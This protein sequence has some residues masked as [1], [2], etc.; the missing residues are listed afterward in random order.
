MNATLIDD[1]TVK[2]DDI[3]KI[4][5]SDFLYLCQLNGVKEYKMLNGDLIIRFVTTESA[6]YVLMGFGAL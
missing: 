3:T 6:L 1:F 4:T 5:T 2:I